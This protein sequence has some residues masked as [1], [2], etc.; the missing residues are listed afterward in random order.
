IIT[1]TLRTRRDPRLERLIGWRTHYDRHQSAIEREVVEAELASY[2]PE[3]IPALRQELDGGSVWRTKLAQGI[4]RKSPAFI[5]ESIGKKQFDSD[6]RREQ[7]AL[8]LGRIGPRAVA[9]IPDLK[10]L[11]ATG[12]SH[13]GLTAEF[14]LAM[15]ARQD[16]IV[17]SN[18]V[19]ALASTQPRRP[20]F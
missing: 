1:L 11:A 15:I 9:A 10:R 18:A 4:E 14:A 2:G 3:I 17:Q 19:A 20:F 7:A 6:R 16:P 5:S 13:L 12:G 8:C